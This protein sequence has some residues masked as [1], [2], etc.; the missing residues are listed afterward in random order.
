[1][2]RNNRISLLCLI[3]IFISILLI[4]L[5]NPNWGKNGDFGIL[6][7]DNFGYYLYLPATFIY[8][9]PNLSSTDWVDNVRSK[10]HPSPAFYQA[11]PLAN[12]NR[13]IQYSMGMALIYSPAFF[14]AHLYATISDSYPAD[15]FSEPYQLA[16]LLESIFLL[17]LELIFLRLLA[18][19]FFS[20]K[21][22]A[23]I[24]LF[25]CLGTNYFQIGITNTT[26]PHAILFTFYSSLLYFTYLWHKK[27][28]IKYSV[29]L[30]ILLG[31]LAL[32]RP[33]E[34][35]FILIPVL[36]NVYSIKSLKEKALFFWDHYLQV[37]I[38]AFILVFFASLQVIYWKV[39]TG[40]WLFDSYTN[41]D[42]KIFRPYLMEYLFSYK[43]GWLL[44]TPIM[45]FV[46]LG[47]LAFFKKNKKL[48][49]P[50]FL[51]AI[52]NI[53]VLSSWDNWWYADSFSQR[54]IVQSYP[55]FVLPLGYLILAIFDMKKWWR[56]LGFTLLFV[57]L[58]FNLFQTY[59]YRKGIIHSQRMTEPYYWAVFGDLEYSPEK[60]HLLD[61]DRS[62]GYL[63]EKLP[64]KHYLIYNNSFLNNE[65]KT[66]FIFQDSIFP[67]EGTMV[68][69]KNNRFSEKVSF[70]FNEL[71]DTNHFYAVTRIRY[72]SEYAAEEN[73]FAIVMLMKDYYNDKTYKYSQ[74]LISEISW[75]EKGSWSSMEL[76][77]IPPYPRSNKDSLQMYLWLIGD[78]PVIIDN[79][80][81]E[82]YD[83]GSK[84]IFEEKKFVNNFQTLNIGNWSE[85]T[86]IVD[87][88]GYA[89][90]NE[91]FPY[92][93]TLHIESDKLPLNGKSYSI[94]CVGL[95]PTAN[96]NLFAVVSVEQN[97]KKTYYKSFPMSF[98][99]G[100]W[101]S[102]RF[103]DKLPDQIPEGSIL[104]Y[105]IWNAS[106]KSFFIDELK[107]VLN[108]KSSNKANSR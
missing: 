49:L 76:V 108:N 86:K 28:E 80:S 104:K 65:N 71:T 101:F 94:E 85:A 82:L 8:D 69:D 98:K 57:L 1:M 91:T 39:T 66:K 83:P 34:I 21:V 7:W 53:W 4:R 15:G 30:G 22:T 84:E 32:S 106:G 62:V 11:H 24:L 2:F 37:I 46:L 78:K 60:Q 33:N 75:F 74:K 41:E 48:F 50:F 99:S 40:Q 103:E 45:I 3:G 97:D 26:T 5:S 42:L 105:Y 12:G 88:K 9:D 79:I 107:L 54:S 52:L 58:S 67:Q 43:K 13:V 95:S 19:Q 77:F 55:V 16:V 25:L 20:D 23:F 64:K 56:I 73:P 31:I 89:L 14:T 6:A 90:V 70:A 38:V 59:Q 87:N 10:Y 61:L 100:Q 44:Y 72:K 18:L 68:L 36:W 35:L 63:P 51:F 93:S 81:M 92:S 29:L 47:F 27:P 102:Y 17:L 96:E